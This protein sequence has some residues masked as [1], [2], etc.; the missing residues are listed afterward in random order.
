MAPGR[1]QQPN[2]PS[3]ISSLESAVREIQRPGLI[4]SVWNWRWELGTAAVTAGLSVAIAANLGLAGLAVIAG[5]GLAAFGAMLRWPPTRRRIIARAWCIITPHRIRTGCVNAWVQTRRGK[6]PIILSTVPTH[7]GERVQLWCRAGIT[8]DDLLAARD[9][10]AASCWAAEVRVIPNARHAHIVTLEVIRNH[11]PE[12]PVQS[13]Q[14]WPFY[15]HAEADAAGEDPEEPA[16]VGPWGETNP[17]FGMV[18]RCLPSGPN[19]PN[20][21]A[22]ARRR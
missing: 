4:Q 5:A 2:D 8:A 15:R 20:G 19:G 16:M 7:F 14:G 9:I 12:R 21:Q 18:S 13:P 11:Y 22:P 1:P 6:L 3:V 17:P 10:I